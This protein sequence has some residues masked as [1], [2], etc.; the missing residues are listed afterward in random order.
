MSQVKGYI[1]LDNYAVGQFTVSQSFQMPP[2]AENQAFKFVAV[3]VVVDQI[4]P[5]SGLP[6]G[7]GYVQ[8][9]Q[10][11]TGNHQNY[12]STFDAQVITE[13]TSEISM[14]QGNNFIVQSAGIFPQIPLRDDMFTGSEISLVASFQKFFAGPLLKIGF[15]IIYSV[16]KVTN[17]E[18]IRL[19]I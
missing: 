16:E 2:L 6:Y 14:A 19:S 5:F 11:L 1:D 18:S 9:L 17:T 4:D 3:D 15:R 7:F 8:R 13:M 12:L 10:L